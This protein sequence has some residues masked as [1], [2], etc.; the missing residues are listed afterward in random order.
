M[1]ICLVSATILEIK[2]T[3]E[4]LKLN[5]T[6]YQ[7][8]H[9]IKGEKEVDIL[10]TGVGAVQTVFGLTKYLQHNKPDICIQAGIAGSFSNK[11]KIGTVY[12]IVEEV[13]A[14]LGVENNDGSFTDAFQVGLINKDQ[15][16]FQSGR[17]LNPGATVMTFLPNAI[18]V[19]TNT[20][21]GT[22]KTIDELI[23]RYHPDVESM[24]GAGFF[25]TCLLEKLP[26]VEI[27][28]I[29]NAVEVRNKEQWNIP[30]AVDNLNQILIQIIESF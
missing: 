25:Y 10:I 7:P 19:T 15:P 13:F 9:F 14:D 28:S 22:H 8:Y 29:S 6:E 21:S 17:L 30:L 23:Q 2:K 18:S 12:N 24:E 1:K 4:A 5:Y 26:F 20:V 3:V 11:I 27:R 16:P